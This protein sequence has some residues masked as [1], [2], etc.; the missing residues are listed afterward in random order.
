[1]KFKEALD[2]LVKTKEFKEWKKKNKDFFLTNAFVKD[3]QMQIGYC[4]K[5]DNKIVSFIIGDE[6]I[7][8]FEDEVFKRP[9]AKIIELTL[10]NVKIDVDKALKIA[11]DKKEEIYSNEDINK[12]IIILHN[13]EQGEI[14]NITLIS[15]SFNMLNFKID[16]K[17]GKLLSHEKRSLLQ[18]GK[19]MK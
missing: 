9:D 11:K 10:D 4:R 15:K 7:E 6:K 13:S 14:W 17:E 19:E 16:A 8:R 1:M 2:R 3:S 18:L 12:N 5:K